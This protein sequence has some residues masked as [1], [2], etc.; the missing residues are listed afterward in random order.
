M[1]LKGRVP[2]DRE[3][4]LHGPIPV[5]PDLA[6]EVL[7]PD[8]QAGRIFERADF[9]MHSGVSIAWFVDPGSETITVY[10]PGQ[11]PTVH[12]PPAVIDAKPVLTDFSLN[13]RA[14]F[15]VL[16]EDEE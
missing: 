2:L 5:Q 6:I 9:Y 11:A 12:C 14:L 7:S 15:A 10:R 16:Y 4:R 3:L 13:L 8:D 1:T